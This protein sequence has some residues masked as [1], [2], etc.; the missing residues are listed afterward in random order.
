MSL[1]EHVL[2][3]HFYMGLRQEL[4]WYIDISFGGSFTHKTPTEGRE[5][6]DRILE[7]TLFFEDYKT[8]DESSHEEPSTTES[9]SLNISSLDSAVETSPEPRIPKEEENQPSGFPSKFEEDLYE[10]FGNT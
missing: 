7:N 10:N 6:L 8:K 2:L 3:Q 4:A 5:I 9:E 1:P